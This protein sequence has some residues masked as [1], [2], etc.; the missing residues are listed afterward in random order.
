MCSAG[1]SSYAVPFD[2]CNLKEY[3][4]V[5]NYVEFRADFQKDALVRLKHLNDKK[6]NRMEIKN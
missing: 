3:A 4:S 6:I 1:H 2:V 5:V